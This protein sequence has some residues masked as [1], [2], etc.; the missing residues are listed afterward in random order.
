[1]ETSRVQST[2]PLWRNNDF[3]LLFTTWADICVKGLAELKSV[4]PV[5]KDLKPNQ[6]L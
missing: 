5:P 1:M 4:S 3:R 2:T 6:S